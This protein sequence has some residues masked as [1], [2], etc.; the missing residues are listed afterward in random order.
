[1]VVNP[2]GTG[3]SGK[4][5]IVRAVMARY[6]T[7]GGEERIFTTGR[8]QPLG[9]RLSA[10]TVVPG[11]ENSLRTLFV[12]GHYE[13]PCGGCDTIKT[14]D[15]VYRLVNEAA[16]R[17]DD[18]IYEGI[19][20]GDDTRR[21]IE[22]NKRFPGQL[23]VV[24]IDT[25]LRDCLAGIQARRDERGDTRQLSEKNTVERAKRIRRH[26]VKLRD[27]GVKVMK[28]EDRDKALQATLELFHLQ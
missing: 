18:V 8:K 7:P 14:P 6:P 21:A 12:P 15:E 9:Y 1:M 28:F 24:H 2:R 25:P 17:G 19:I 4:S 26:C 22:F 3:G 20:I 27:A 11:G 13:T 5:T 10:L 16:E 23:V